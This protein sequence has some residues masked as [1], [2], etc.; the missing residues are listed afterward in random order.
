MITN[1]P[2]AFRS[3]TNDEWVWKEQKRAYRGLKYQDSVVLDIG[4]HGGFFA[5]YAL[6]Q[7]A[8]RVTGYEPDPDNFNLARQ[9]LAGMPCVLY[10]AAVTSQSLAS[11]G[12]VKLY[13]N[14]GSNRGSHSLFI[15]GG[16]TAIDVHAVSFEE[17]LAKEQYDIVKIDIE[18]GEYALDLRLLPSSVNMV[19]MELHL[20]KR[21]W[22]EH[23]APHIVQTLEHL[24]FEAIKEPWIGAKN[25][26]T[27]AVWSRK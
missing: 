11:T 25:W 3:G 18:G 21:Q 5:R 20:N 2:L 13:S 12:V 15:K 24:G 4:S 23:F 14:S 26:T 17:V 7:G 19:A 22:R 9:N 16:R 1:P 8:E 6:S 27:T 10:N